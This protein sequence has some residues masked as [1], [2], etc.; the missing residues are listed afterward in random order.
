MYVLGR[1]GTYYMEARVSLN[2][3]IIITQ[4]AYAEQGFD[5]YMGL[6]IEWEEILMFVKFHMFTQFLLN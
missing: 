6:Y 1:M 2:N 3:E 4:T 5:K